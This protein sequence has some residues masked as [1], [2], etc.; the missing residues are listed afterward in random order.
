MIATLRSHPLLR[1]LRA[2][3]LCCAL[4]ALTQQACRCCPNSYISSQAEGTLS[5]TLGASETTPVQFDV[6]ALKVNFAAEACFGRVIL[7]RVQLVYD[8]IVYTASSPNKPSTTEMTTQEVIGH[9]RAKNYIEIPLIRL[10]L[11][12]ETCLQQDP[13]DPSSYTCFLS[14]DQQQKHQAS[15][16][17]ELGDPAQYTPQLTSAWKRPCEVAAAAEQGLAKKPVMLFFAG[18]LEDNEASYALPPLTGKF[19]LQCK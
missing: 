18:Y 12:F 1:K 6:S 17:L 2:F 8:P 13:Q 4:F 5:V 3:A 14:R 19:I 15:L 10:P 16:A 11:A 9:L 7:Q